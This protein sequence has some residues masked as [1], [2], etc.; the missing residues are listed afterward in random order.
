MQKLGLEMEMVVARGD[1][2][3][4][5][6]VCR[7]FKALADIKRRRGLEAS[8]VCIQSRP[9][10]VWC[11]AVDS[12]LD[13]AFNHLES[14]LG[15]FAGGRGGLDRLETAVVSELG[16]VL[17]ALQ[18]DGAVLLNASEHPD[19]PLDEDFYAVAR[20]PKPIYD[21]WVKHR[22]WRHHVGIDAKAQNGP[23]TSVKVEDAARALN[24]MLGLAPAFIGLFANSPLEAGRPTGYK[25]NRLTIWDRMFR[26]GR[27]PADLEA[28]RTPDKP[29]ADL[30]AYFRRAYGKGTVMHTVPLVD[31]QDYKGDPRTVRVQGDPCLLDFL[32]AGTARGVLA[33]SGRCVTVEPSA[34]H[35][36]H[37]QF[38]PFLDARFRFRFGSHPSLEA[39]QA[40]LSSPGGVE[41][42][43]ARHGVEAYIEGRVPGAG[44]ADADLLKEMG[45]ACS[46]ASVVMSP[47]ALQQGLLNNLDE[48]TRLVQEWGW[49]RLQ[50]LR[51]AAIAHALD[52]GEVWRLAGE[53]IA[54]AQAG[55]DAGERRHLDYARW[56]WRNRRTG[57]DRM[58]ETWKRLS[59]SPADRLRALAA[60]RTVVHPRDWAMSSVTRHGDDVSTLS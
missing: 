57:A 3:R 10:A 45:G 46:A 6:L 9:V 24:A 16:D 33:G 12:G 53:V 23:T 36:E 11:D 51:Q 14:A 50:G 39:L 28:C 15:P 35:F 17:D 30:G 54:V 38:A 4:S 22:G 43:M 60:K 47:S 42:M 48:A 26:S 41:A 31:T 27:F 29:F 34:S 59:G 7:Y 37:M 32:A 40:A 13:N 55:L 49:Q 52:D 25:E 2:G 56:V 44:F 58:L 19:C 20:A 1:T 5:H 21:Y 18:A 8:I